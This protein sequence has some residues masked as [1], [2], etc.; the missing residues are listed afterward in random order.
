MEIMRVIWDAGSPVTAAELLELFSHKGWK[1]QTMSTFLSRLVEKGVL[2]VERRGRSNFY[3]PAVTEQ[4]YQKLEAR[5]LVDEHYHGDLLDF[6]A[7]FY[8]GEPLKKEELDTLRRWF[9]QE[10][11]HAD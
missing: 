7:A 10:A 3:T 11:E 6:L 9:E 2:S 8:G 5:R 1:I 4:G